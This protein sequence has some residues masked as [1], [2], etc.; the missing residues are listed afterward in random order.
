MRKR[1]NQASREAFWGCSDFPR[2]KGTL[3]WG[4]PV[5]DD[6]LFG[7]PDLARL[8]EAWRNEVEFL[9][10][11]NAQLESECQRL[12]L[13]AA[14]IPQEV[15]VRELTRLIG[16]CH[17]DKWGGESRVA[18]ALTQELLALRRRLGASR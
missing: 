18:T 4:D 1:V 6:N 8:L 5:P 11:R 3:P 15:L 10:Q 17:P 9:R 13:A 2:C 7:Q 12:S 14:P 16:V